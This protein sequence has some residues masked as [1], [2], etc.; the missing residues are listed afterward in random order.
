[1]STATHLHPPRLLCCQRDA[2][3]HRAVSESKGPDS[4]PAHP[5]SRAGPAKLL[6]IKKKK[7]QSLGWC[8]PDWRAYQPHLMRR[9]GA[10]ELSPGQQLLLVKIMIVFTR[11]K[12]SLTAEKEFYLSRNCRACV[13]IAIYKKDLKRTACEELVLLSPRPDENKG[14]YFNFCIYLH[15]YLHKKQLAFV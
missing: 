7:D 13:L 1:M 6:L 5:W 8:F 11:K 10:A 3:H 9:T 14:I 4:G 12:Y 2:E 15:T